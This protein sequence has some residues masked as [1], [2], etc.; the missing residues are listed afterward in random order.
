MRHIVFTQSDRYPVVLLIKSTAFQ[1][2][3]IETAYKTPLNAKGIT[4]DQLLAMTAEYNDKGKAPVKFIKEYLE[5]L[6]PA[7][8]SLGAKVIYCADAAYFKVLTGQ[9]KA[10]P[11]LG[12]VLPCKVKGYEH[13][14]VVLG[15]NHKSLVYNPANEPKLSLSLNTLADVVN[16]TYRALGENIIKHAQYPASPEEIKQALSK[17]HRYPSLGV[18]IEAFS[19]NFNEAGVGTITFCWNEHEGIAFACDYFELDSPVDGI[20]GEYVPNP[21][22]RALLR[23]FFETY[24]GNLKWHNAPYDLKCIILSLWMDNLSDVPGMLNGLEIMTQDFHDTKI[25]TYLAV[26]SCAGNKLG[27]KE[28][29]HEFA[30]NWANENIKDIRRIPLKDLLQY[31]LVDGLST[32]YTFNKHYPTVVED[33]QEE[34]YYSMMLPSLRTIIQME[35]VGMPLSPTKV[36]EARQQLE[37][38]IKHHEQVLRSSSTSSP[39]GK[40]EQHIRHKAMVDANAKLKVKQHPIEHFN[41]LMFNPNSG[42][43]KQTLLYEIMGLPVIDKTDS[44]A[45]ATGG[46]TL[47]KLSHHT[48]DPEALAILE[49]LQGHAEADKILGTFIKAFEKAIDKGDD[50]VWLHG[51]FNLGGTKSG[52]LSSS[53]PNLQNMPSGST[54][55]KLI[56]AC[57]VAPKGWLFGGADFN[58]LNLATS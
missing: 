24:K 35:M 20:Y 55:G 16:D 17:L 8:D 1:Q 53:D 31:N 51:S 33:K 14:N 5:T 22:V 44:G 11:H 32:N 4:D 28:Q 13:F 57:F 45:P 50:V 58:S 41:G 39:I 19:L 10:E 42:P 46:D 52:R 2:T 6:L 21:E 27:L 9:R 34:L 23:E 54:Y 12:Y 40:L 29:A 30:G 7:I 26:N 36:K 18:D 38:I 48:K 49:A 25:L 15:V 47:D 3:E 56:K 43:Q 37:A